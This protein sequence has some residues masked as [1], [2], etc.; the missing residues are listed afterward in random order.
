VGREPPLNTSPTVAEIA[1]ALRSAQIAIVNPIKDK[2]AKAGAYSYTYAD[3]GTVID[4]L[5]PI[6]NE[7]GLCFVQDTLEAEGGVKVSTRILHTSGEWIEFG[8]L[9][10]PAAD[11][12]QALGSAITYGRRYQLSA[13]F[14]VAAEDDDGASAGKRKR[15]VSG[16]AEAMG[17]G[18]GSPG[19]SEQSVSAPRQTANQVVAV[20]APEVGRPRPAGELGADTT[21]SPAPSTGTAGEGATADAGP[22][23]AGDPATDAEWRHVAAQGLTAAKAK[24]IAKGLGIEVKQAYELTSDQ[25]RLVMLKATAATVKDR[26][27]TTADL[28]PA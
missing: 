25:L 23:P 27:S 2:T 22:S 18:N 6:L 9:Y 21:S 26:E 19:T 11:T 1:G 20:E 16:G 12:A 10:L 15:D 4:S 24:A 7:F 28:G 14:G 3:L 5:R 8:P 13:A 17:K